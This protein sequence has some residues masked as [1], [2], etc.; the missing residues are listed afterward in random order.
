[1]QVASAS[2]LIANEAVP[3]PEVGSARGLRTQ[4]E[5]LELKDACLDKEAQLLPSRM[6]GVA[7]FACNQL[8]SMAGIKIESAGSSC[9]QKVVCTASSG[10]LRSSWVY[11]NL[12]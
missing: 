6:T 9:R 7:C 8:H 10:I 12:L 3:L 1:M 4:A 2:S 5:L 11:G